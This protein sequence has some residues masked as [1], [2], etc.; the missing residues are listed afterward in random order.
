FTL[1][2]SVVVL[3][4]FFIFGFFDVLFKN[5]CELLARGCFT[6]GWVCGL[7]GVFTKNPPGFKKKN[8]RGG[9]PIAGHK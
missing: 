3:G 1:V 4:V 2:F 5:G 6:A 9:K 8:P 7:I